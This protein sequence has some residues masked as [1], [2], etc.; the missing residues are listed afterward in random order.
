MRKRI[1]LGLLTAALTV[2]LTGCGLRAPEELYALPDPS[3]EYKSL[4]SSLESLLNMGYEY[5]A[6]APIP[7]PSSWRIWTATA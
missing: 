2:A 3:P 6:P 7:S 5:A 1:L 4:Q